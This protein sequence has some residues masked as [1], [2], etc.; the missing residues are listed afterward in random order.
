MSV[1]PY[2]EDSVQ[3]WGYEF[4]PYASRVAFREHSRGRQDETGEESRSRKS[5]TPQALF[6]TVTISEESALRKEPASMC[7]VTFSGEVSRRVR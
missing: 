5:E 1:T 3:V 2:L 4:S 6:A 7:P